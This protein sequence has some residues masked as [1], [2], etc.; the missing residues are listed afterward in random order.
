MKKSLPSKMLLK[1]LL[2]L[3]TIILSF[4]ALSIT[5]KSMLVGIGSW[6]KS[7]SQDILV[8]N[9][10]GHLNPKQLTLINSGFSTFSQMQ[11]DRLKEEEEEEKPESDAVLFKVS[12]TVKFDTWQERYDVAR[13]TNNPKAAVVKNFKDYADLCLTA[14]ITGL[15]NLK[16]LKNDGGDLKATLLIDQISIAK[17]LLPQAL[18]LT[19][20]EPRL[21]SHSQYLH[22]HAI[23]SDHM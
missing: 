23:T 22:Y 14:N 5:D 16:M 3:V 20:K 8:I 11:I 13:I 18:V 21:G 1:I 12:C 17:H 15:K 4:N 10:V 9:L 19:E 2:A 6:K 7:N